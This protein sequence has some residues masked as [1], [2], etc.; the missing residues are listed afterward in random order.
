[1]S[2]DIGVFKAIQDQIGDKMGIELAKYTFA[3]HVIASCEAN[4]EQPGKEMRRRYK[5]LFSPV[6]REATPG[7]TRTRQ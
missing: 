1:M 5:A 2:Q 6:D 7:R 3:R 4:K